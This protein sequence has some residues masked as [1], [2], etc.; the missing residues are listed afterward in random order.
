MRVDVNKLKGKIAENQ[1]TPERVA[2]AIG[3]DGSTF[4]RKLKA[5]GL[6]FTVEQMH[7]IVDVLRLSK[8]EA[9]Q[10]FLQ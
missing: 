2:S 4:Y 5:N 6:T 9:T 7:K 10:I 1:L 3:I 8:E